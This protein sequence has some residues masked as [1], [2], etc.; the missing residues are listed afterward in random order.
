MTEER[1]K[2][3][4]KPMRIM[5]KGKR[6][7]NICIEREKHSLKRKTTDKRKIIEGRE[8]RGKNDGENLIRVNEEWRYC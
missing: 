5:L 8:L 3:R 6:N 7:E 2:N 1:K 4:R